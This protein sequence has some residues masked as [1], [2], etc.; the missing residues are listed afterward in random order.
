MKKTIPAITAHILAIALL[1]LYFGGVFGVRNIPSAGPE[2]TEA[3]DIYAR[4][5]GEL[6]HNVTLRVLEN[7]TAVRQGYFAYLLEA[8]NAEYAQYGIV[9][10]DAN[11]DEYSDLENDGP[12]GYGP[13]VLYQAND[14]VMQYPE[15]KHILPLPVDRLECFAQ[16]DE[17]AWEVYAAA[18]GLIYGVPVNIQAPVLY[19]RK[20]MLPENWEQDWDANQNGIPDFTEDWSELYAYSQQIREESGGQ[21]FGYMKSLYDVY[22]ASG[23]LFSYGGYVFGEG[24]DTKDIGFAAKGAVTGAAI[25]RQL[26]TLMNEDCIDVTVTS[27]AYSKI[28]SGEYFA[29]MTTPD[30][31]TLFL[32]DLQ[33]AYQREGLSES[34]ALQKATEN[35]IVSSVPTLP[36]SGDL[37]DRSGPRIPCKMM[38]GVNGYAVSS[39]TKSPNAALAFVDF[40]TQYECLLQRNAYLGITPARRDA[41]DAI[42]G[43]TQ[44]VNLALAEGNLIIMPSVRATGQIWIPMQ[45]L[46]SDIAKDPFR[47]PGEQKYTSMEAL[48][49]GLEK[50]SR[51][52]YDAI[53]T[54]Q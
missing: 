27:T 14:Q 44:I 20:D 35:L 38:G 8:F 45:T 25:I 41:A 30:V 4:F 53:W 7:D 1:L 51:Q 21:K 43:L 33:L 32:R 52:V 49:E 31:Y 40:A 24:N 11:M 28:A 47:L 17:S 13:D 34:D 54:L 48:Q 15:G 29:T 9:A 22:F 46:F 50:A 26:A 10:V 36:A 2:S 6:E 23:Y 37:T 39:Y 16:V 18:D 42:G 12:Y 19:Y 3:P 5:T